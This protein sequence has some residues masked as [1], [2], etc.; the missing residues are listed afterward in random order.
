MKPVGV[1]AML[2]LNA[3]NMR[4]SQEKHVHLMFA[5]HNTDSAALIQAANFVGRDAKATARS[6]CLVEPLVM[7]N[8]A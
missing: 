6:Q 1:I 3:E 8:R 5:V 4:K 7:C 2:T